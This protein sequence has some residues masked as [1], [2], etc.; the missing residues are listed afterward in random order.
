M[1]TIFS[2]TEAI[3]KHNCLPIELVHEIT[4]GNSITL[5]QIIRDE[6]VDLVKTGW[7]IANEC[8]LTVD[9]L[10]EF[11]TGCLKEASE[12]LQLLNA[13]LILTE[14]KSRLR[15]PKMYIAFA[16]NADDYDKIYASCKAATLLKSENEMYAYFLTFIK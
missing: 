5:E 16:F 4:Q 6:R 11:A 3:S 8:E 1:K 15:R 9:E 13:R 10:S 12:A 7:F 14:S 2:Y